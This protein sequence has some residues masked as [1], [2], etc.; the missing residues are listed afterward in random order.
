MGWRWGA[1]CCGCLLRG[2]GDDVGV[3]RLSGLGG[4]WG[5]VRGK[6][7]VGVSEQG[8]QRWW[9]RCAVHTRCVYALGS[10]ACERGTGE[11]R[12]SAARHPAM[13]ARAGM[14]QQALAWA[15]HAQAH[16][17]ACTTHTHTTAQHSAQHAARHT[18]TRT[19]VCQLRRHACSWAQLAQHHGA[20]RLLAGQR[21]VQLL[22]Q[23]AARSLV[24]L[25]CARQRG[26]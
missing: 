4:A 12:R 9:G 25:L 11:G 1:V 6:R 14:R 15:T 16:C 3:A 7:H 18:Q 17:K 22:G 5:F 20:S 2:T 26:V 24:K 23:A 21:D 19:R 13:H 10:A 8:R